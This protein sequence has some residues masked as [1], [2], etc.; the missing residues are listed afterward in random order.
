M[1]KPTIYKLRSD[2]KCQYLVTETEEGAFVNQTFGTP[3]LEQ[4]DPPLCR[5]Y[6]PNLEPCDFMWVNIWLS[7]FAIRQGDPKMNCI[8]GTW[9][10]AGELLPCYVGPEKVPYWILNVT[11]CYNCLDHERTTKKVNAEGRQFGWDKLVFQKNMIPESSLFKIPEMSQSVFT[12][13]NVFEVEDEF[14]RTVQDH[15][16]RGIRFEKVWEEGDG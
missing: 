4:W 3:L 2:T 13:S 15:G 1:A 7:S 12:H 9:E 5:N 11:Q 8:R 6:E 16:L 14:Y 10:R